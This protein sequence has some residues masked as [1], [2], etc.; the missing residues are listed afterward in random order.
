MLRADPLT[1]ARD[2][3]LE[4]LIDFAPEAWRWMGTE[5][6]WGNVPGWVGAILTG[7][8]F[9]LG[10]KIMRENQLRDRRA[11]ASKIITWTTWIDGEAQGPEADSCEVHLTNRSDA[12]IFNP[13]IHVVPFHHLDATPHLGIWSHAALDRDHRFLRRRKE[14]RANIMTY[15]FE[16]RGRQVVAVEPSETVSGNVGTTTPVDMWD[17]LVSFRDASGVDWV[18]NVRTAEFS[19][20]PPAYLKRRVSGNHHGP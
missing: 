7:S 12:P 19:T 11:Q 5:A 10:F 16:P 4:W 1:D 2:A 9:L 18:R 15:V 8:S 3:G 13:L 17:I 14:Q 20:P 6:D